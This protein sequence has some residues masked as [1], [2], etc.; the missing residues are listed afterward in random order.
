M[1][2]YILD[3]VTNSICE[4]E[5]ERISDDGIDFTEILQDEYGL[6]IDGISYMYSENKLSI[7]ELKLL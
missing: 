5:D 1:Y 3:Y 4:I 6:D 7:E 2:C